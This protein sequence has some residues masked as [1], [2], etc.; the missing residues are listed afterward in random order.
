MSIVDVDV[1]LEDLEEAAP[2]GPNLEYD[3]AFME[4]EQSALGNDVLM[5]V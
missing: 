4:L 2:C 3:P 5:F 1:L